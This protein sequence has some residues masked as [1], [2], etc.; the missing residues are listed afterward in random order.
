MRGGRT[1]YIR[2]HQC[3]VRASKYRLE[4]LIFIAPHIEIDVPKV[5][6]VQLLNN[7]KGAGSDS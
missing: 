4:L 2:V 1:K 5:R 6:N 7:V 3:N